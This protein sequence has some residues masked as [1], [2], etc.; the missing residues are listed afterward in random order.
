MKYKWNLKRGNFYK[1]KEGWFQKSY[2]IIC[3]SVD[4][5]VGTVYWHDY[6]DM[7]CIFAIRGSG[8]KS[9]LCVK[10]TV[11]LVNEFDSPIRPLSKR[12]YIKVGRPLKKYGYIF[13][14]RTSR[15]I[16]V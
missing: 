12:D 2:T 7:F 11:R 6:C 9:E 13:N 14:K 16:K 4:K 15:L 8:K 5:N 1:I 3:P 10:P